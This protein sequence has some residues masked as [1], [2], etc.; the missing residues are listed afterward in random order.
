MQSGAKPKG[1]PI[2]ETHSKIAGTTILDI[3]Q[4]G[5]KL[6]INSAGETKGKYNSRDMSTT[7]V[8][9]KTDGTSEWETKGLQNTKDGD[10][11]AVWGK[12]TGK[13]SGPTSQAW[14]GEM[15]VMTQSPK[16]AWMNTAKLWIEGSGDQAKGE[17]HAKI[18]QQM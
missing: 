14:E 13:S 12:G 9:M 15:H 1:E 17:S 3:S 7:T 6:E 10:T 2:L 8:W 16:L 5:I 4:N 18:Y 11:L